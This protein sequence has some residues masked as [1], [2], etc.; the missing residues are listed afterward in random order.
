MKPTHVLNA[1]LVLAVAALAVWGFAQ[2]SDRQR[3]AD[4]VAALEAQL[5]ERTKA[6]P[7]IKADASVA[8]NSAAQP[9]DG[10]AGSDDA[11]T[12][13]KKEENPMAAFGKGLSEMMDNPAMKEM[14][15]TQVRGMVDG[16]YKDLFEDLQLTEEQREV[17]AALLSERLLAQQ[18]LGMKMLKGGMTK[19]ERDK[20]GEELKTAKAASD[21]KVKEAL[22]D[23]AK[24]ERFERYEDS[25]PERQ[26]I[27]MLKGALTKAGEPLTT[28]Q[29]EKL[30]AAMYSE[31]KAF[32]FDHNY[33]DQT[34]VNPEKFSEPAIGRYQEQ[35]KQLSAKID[36]QAAGFLSEKQLTSFRD[37]R[38]QMQ[39]MEKMGLEMAKKMFAGSEGGGAPEK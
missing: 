31:R 7:P 34:D 6:P 21:E 24:V 20:L 5:A 39:A 26:Q 37:T 3:L 36:A 25:Q 17:L 32:K 2:K 14:M 19:E 30:M 10:A 15:A 35:S 29:E 12:K 8:K 33:Q 4:R 11:K 28:E 27:G 1:V 38:Q 23:P 18:S 9:T 22:G 13:K 16:T